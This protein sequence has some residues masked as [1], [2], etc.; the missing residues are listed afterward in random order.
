VAAFK[1][2]ARNES[3][4]SGARIDG[5]MS[6]IPDGPRAD[7]TD[8]P[9][10][11]APTAQTS[12]HPRTV[13]AESQTSAPTEHTSRHP[14]VDGADIP[15]VRA[16]TCTVSPDVRASVAQTSHTSARRRSG[17]PVSPASARPRSSHPGSGRRRSR[18]PPHPASSPSSSNSFDPGAVATIEQQTGGQLE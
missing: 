9:G 13:G 8:T 18:H 12:R 4:H 10:V 14:R 1:A 16:P 15:A 17:Y 7:G 11:R 5:A 2:S 6:D 3:G